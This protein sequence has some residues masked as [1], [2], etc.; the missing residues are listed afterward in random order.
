MKLRRSH[1]TERHATDIAGGGP[2][3]AAVWCSRE[4]RLSRS[5]ASV[6]FHVSVALRDLVA[7]RRALHAA[8]GAALGL[9]TVSIHN[10]N[11]RAAL[12]LQLAPHCVGDAMVVIMRSVPQAQFGMVC[13]STRDRAH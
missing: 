7:T 1:A 4:S 3:G 6:L 10:R 11:A 13:P 12:Q 2:T 8:F 9:N 5:A